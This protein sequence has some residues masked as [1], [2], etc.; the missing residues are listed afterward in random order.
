MLCSSRKNVNREPACNIFR[1]PVKIQQ[2]HN[3]Y[4]QI[5]KVFYNFEKKKKKKTY[6]TEILLTTGTIKVKFYLLY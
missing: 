1:P 3:D 4:Q 5:M 2:C 6:K